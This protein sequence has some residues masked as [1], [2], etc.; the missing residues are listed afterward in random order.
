MEYSCKRY[1][2]VVYGP[3]Y[4]LVNVVQWMSIN[5][6]HVG[7]RESGDLCHLATNFAPENVIAFLPA[8][9]PRHIAA[10]LTGHIF[11]HLPR[12]VAALLTGNIATLLAWHIAA[13]LARD[14]AALLS[15]N[16]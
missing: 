4:G 11:A 3:I 1:I 9:L 10:F 13:L 14:T 12:D 6:I 16:V 2:F 8:L 7:S 15:R 5:Y